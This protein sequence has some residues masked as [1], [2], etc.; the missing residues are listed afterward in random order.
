MTS[1]SFLRISSLAP[2]VA[3]LVPFAMGCPEDHDVGSD[4]SDGGT[5][6]SS[7]SNCD[8]PQTCEE[9]N[10]PE[11]CHLGEGSCN[12]GVYTCPPVVCPADAGS[13]DSTGIACS[14]PPI[15]LGCS[16]GPAGCVDGVYQCPTVVCPGGDAGTCGGQ[17]V[18][19]NEPTIPEGCTLGTGSCVDGVYQCPG[20]ICPADAGVG[21]S[22][23]TC[24]DID[25]SSYSKACT[26]ASDCILVDQGELCSGGCNC[27]TVTVSASEQQRYDNAI[28]GITLN[29]ECGCPAAVTPSC[30]AGTCVQC[31]GSPSDPPACNSGDA[32]VTAFACG[33]G[34]TTCNPL[35][36]YCSIIQ[37]GAIQPDGGTTMND[38][39]VA[40]PSQCADDHAG[41]GATCACIQAQV[42][43]NCTVSNGDLT[44]T[45]DVP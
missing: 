19:C 28:A 12:D 24:V 5:V 26:Q 30:I 22:G 23:K 43:G 45:F 41:A 31:T 44:V 3:L 21:D 6:H 32:S 18:V 25:T 17:P 14:V 7:S 40:I 29:G 38:S 34:T 27:P 16:L 2:I 39:C 36:Q 11:G 15:P 10:I 1:R 20:V 9:P 4:G 13:C 37:G 42:G 8:G 33:D 35:T